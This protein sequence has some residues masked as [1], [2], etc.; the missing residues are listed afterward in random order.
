MKAAIV[1]RKGELSIEEIPMPQVNPYAALCKILYG[2]TCTATD[3]HIISH[4]VLDTDYPTLLGH[5]S[6]GLIL[7]CGG[8]VRHFHQGDRV[9]NVGVPPIPELGLFSFGGG[10]AEYGLIFDNAAMC[11]DGLSEKE[12]LRYTVGIRPLS[13]RIPDDIPDTVAPMLITWR[14]TYSFI[15][16]MGLTPG[17]QVL[18]N[19]SGGNGLS[20][21]SH[22]KALAAQKIV[23]VGSANRR[24]QAIACGADVYID[25]RDPES[26]G[27]LRQA[28]GAGFHCVVDAIGGAGLLDQFL[29]FIAQDAVVGIYGIEGR[30]N[31]AMNPFAAVH[32]FRF[33]NDG[34][35]EIE[36]H[37]AV[38][39]NI[40]AGFLQ[41]GNFYRVDKPYRLTD[42]HEAF[43][44]LQR[45]EQP[46]ALIQM[47]QD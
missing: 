25:Y 15:T 23:A 8:K 46:K 27:L 11:E 5:E 6:I 36:A 40:R 9:T 42:L 39:A 12:I 19:G 18:V 35:K 37:E 4:T 47:H 22:A 14:E 34:Y 24:E 7:E 21:I 16:R 3:Q 13:S 45:K 10:Y 44:M 2:A 41:V 26:T 1:R 29:P 32:S 38:L 17:M 33:Y 28:A 31:M 43:A 20:F 30:K